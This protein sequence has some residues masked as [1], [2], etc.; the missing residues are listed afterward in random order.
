MSNI[1]MVRTDLA[2]EARE[3]WD[4]GARDGDELP[5]VIS[6]ERSRRGFPVTE[7]EIV[8]QRGADALCKPIGKYITLELDKLLRREEDSFA[9]CA[10]VL[11]LIHI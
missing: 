2:L 8:D 10:Q 1:S 5:G 3:V 7:V 4:E 9:D 6:R 11:S